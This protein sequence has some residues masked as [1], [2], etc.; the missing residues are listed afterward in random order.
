[1]HGGGSGK[2]AI[3]G[4]NL[5][6]FGHTLFFQE[7][8][9]EGETLIGREY[10]FFPNMSTLYLWQCINWQTLGASWSQ[11]YLSSRVKI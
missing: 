7:T 10:N 11:Y 5:L 1:M 2:V 4:K 6:Q 9:F 8:P 3:V